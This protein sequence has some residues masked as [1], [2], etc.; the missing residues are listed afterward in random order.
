MERK[1]SLVSAKSNMAE[2]ESFEIRKQHLLTSYFALRSS[3]ELTN[4]L[5]KYQRTSAL[6][7]IDCTAIM[8][9]RSRF[10]AA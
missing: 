10:V 7:T 6:L 5:M 3:E 1:N 4:Y 9:C 2:E 8:S